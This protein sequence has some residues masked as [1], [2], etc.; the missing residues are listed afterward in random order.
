MTSL[1]YDKSAEVVEPPRE[2][3]VELEVSDT[4]NEPEDTDLEALERDFF[5]IT[6]TKANKTGEKGTPVSSE[7]M[8]AAD[9]G[10]LV[11]K[12]RSPTA[13]SEEEYTAAA[14]AKQKA[15]EARK[16]AAE[17]KKAAK[18]EA[19]AAKAEAK[20]A[21]AEAK[22]KSKSRGKGKAKAKAKAKGKKGG[23][24]KAVDMVAHDNPDSFLDV[25]FR[26]NPDLPRKVQR[27][28]VR[29]RAYDW[30]VRQAEAAGNSHDDALASARPFSLRM[31]EIWDA[32]HP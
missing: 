26:D 10:A 8:S 30:K 2:P 13:P 6:P 16:E 3:V 24:R 14:K 9:I 32:T 4:E 21:K 12:A 17:A 7:K 27:E 25:M 31:L 5:T 22:A 19:K 18:A 20:A 29:S 15:A 11:A 1:V 23:K 28:R